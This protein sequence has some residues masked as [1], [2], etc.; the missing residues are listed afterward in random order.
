VYRG[1]HNHQKCASW[2]AQPTKNAVTVDTTNKNAQNMYGLREPVHLVGFGNH[3]CTWWA[4]ENQPLLWWASGNQPL[5]QWASENRP[6]ASVGFGEPT[7]LSGLRG[8]NLFTRWASKNQ[9]HLVGFS[10]NIAVFI[11]KPMK[12]TRR[13]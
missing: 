12:S 8:T 5:F 1:W 13:H 6:S 9:P 10:V 3:L 4:S 7:S 11:G 2:L